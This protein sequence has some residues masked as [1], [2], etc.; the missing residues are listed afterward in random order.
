MLADRQGVALAVYYGCKFQW[1]VIYKV[2]LT[3]FNAEVFLQDHAGGSRC[4]WW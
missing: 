4:F 2:S 1:Y 3:L